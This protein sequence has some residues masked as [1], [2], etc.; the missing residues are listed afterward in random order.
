MM[1]TDELEVAGAHERRFH[2]AAD[3]LRAADRIARLEVPRA[4]S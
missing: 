2:G 1:E 4:V 3:R